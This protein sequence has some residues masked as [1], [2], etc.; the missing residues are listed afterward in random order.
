[1]ARSKNI[2]ELANH[3]FTTGDNFIKIR[4]D[5]MKVDQ[6]GEKIRNKHVYANPLNPLAF[7]VPV[8]GVWITLESKKLGLT[9]SLFGVENVGADAPKNKYTSS[10]S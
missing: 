3:N 2:G 5:K 4:Y 7:P 8:L 1:M 10:L 9:T 6:D